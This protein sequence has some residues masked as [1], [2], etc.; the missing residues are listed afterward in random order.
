VVQEL[1]MYSTTTNEAAELLLSWMYDTAH[2]PDDAIT[3]PLVAQL[4]L[5]NNARL[6]HSRRSMGLQMDA[7]GGAVVQPGSDCSADEADAAAPTADT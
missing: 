7:A 2:V 5:G 4:W 6:L 3:C 1:K